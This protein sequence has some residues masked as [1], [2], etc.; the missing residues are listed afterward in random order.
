MDTQTHTLWLTDTH[1]H[2]HCDTH[3]HTQTHCDTQTHTCTHT[4]WHTRTHTLTHTDTHTPTWT[5]TRA[6]TH[7]VIHGYTHAH[8]DTRT[9]TDTHTHCDT[10]T[11]YTTDMLWQRPPGRVANDVA[12]LKANTNQH[13]RLGLTALHLL[14]RMQCKLSRWKYLEEYTYS[15]FRV[16]LSQLLGDKEN[17]LW[18]G[19][20]PTSNLTN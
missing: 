12:G 10:D 1:M 8:C 3:G 5:H 19:R 6:H 13:S 20:F 11:Q 7:T 16:E 14:Q 4:L 9:H 18:H 17:L 15:F 2:T